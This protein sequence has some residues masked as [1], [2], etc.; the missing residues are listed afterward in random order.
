[1]HVFLIIATDSLRE[2][3]VEVTYLKLKFHT[4][5]N[6]KNYFEKDSITQTDLNK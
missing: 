1:M 2:E 4:I 5:I 6:F 3:G